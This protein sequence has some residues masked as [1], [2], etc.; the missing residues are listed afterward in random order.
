MLVLLFLHFLDCKTNRRTTTIL[1]ASI[2]LFNNFKKSFMNS[3]IYRHSCNW[4]IYNLSLKIWPFIIGQE[5]LFQYNRVHT[6][7]CCYDYNVKHNGRVFSINMMLHHNFFFKVT[8]HKKCL[9][10][11]LTYAP[12]P[13]GISKQSPVH[14]S[15]NSWI[16]NNKMNYKIKK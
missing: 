14:R 7:F 6:K 13:K 15:K 10:K 9:C 5:L 1:K 16:N 3:V 2:M 11:I 12:P 4:I 8:G